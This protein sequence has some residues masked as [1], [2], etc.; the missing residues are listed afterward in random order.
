MWHMRVSDCML[1]SAMEPQTGQAKARVCISMCYD[2][3]P[4]EA[5]SCRHVPCCGTCAVV[6]SVQYMDA[7]A[8]HKVFGAVLLP[9]LQRRSSRRVTDPGSSL[10]D[11]V[12]VTDPC[13]MMSGWNRHGQQCTA[14][15]VFVGVISRIHPTFGNQ[16]SYPFFNKAVQ[17]SSDWTLFV[18]VQLAPQARL[19]LI[20]SPPDFLSAHQPQSPA[21]G[22]EIWFW[23]NR[24][25]RNASCSWL[26]AM[27]ARS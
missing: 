16:A 9:C 23:A 2:A 20:K 24:R 19:T 4:L 7:V 15:T 12:Q 11:Q 27:R 22:L 5:G 1:P 3:H 8:W 21:G 25:N 10:H 13:G 26:Q 6:A 17:A 18:D 14:H